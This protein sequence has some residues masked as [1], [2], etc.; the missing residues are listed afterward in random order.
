MKRNQTL[1]K[2]VEAEK[3]IN[4]QTSEQTVDIACEEG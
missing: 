3:Q 1:S 4:N 2:K